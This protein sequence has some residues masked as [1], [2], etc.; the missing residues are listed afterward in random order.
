MR[1]FHS[2]ASVASST[3]G[4]RRT[5]V[6]IATRAFEPR[7]VRAEAGVDA[8]AER[9]VLRGVGAAQVEPVGVGAPL[10]RDRGS[11]SRGTS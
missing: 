3:F 2:G 6:P 9:H 4:K 8:A 10:R 7:E 5:S 1:P 11:P